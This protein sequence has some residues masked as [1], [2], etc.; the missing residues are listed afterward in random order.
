MP[1]VLYVHSN[2]VID[3]VE[4]LIYFNFLITKVQNLRSRE[5]KC[6]APE[7]FFVAIFFFDVD[8]LKSLY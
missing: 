1:Y 8:H 6:L 5:I 2:V 4:H 7:F 3:L